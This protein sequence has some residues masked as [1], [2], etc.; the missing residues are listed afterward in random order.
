MKLFL[1]ST[2]VFASLLVSAGA[3]RAECN[4]L[5]VAGD[6]S[7]KIQ[8][9]V[10]E[11]DGL[12]VRGD[13][14]AALEIYASA[15]ASANDSVLL[16][17]QAMCQ[18]QLGANDDAAAM[19]EAY[20]E[21]GGDLAFRAQAEGALDDVRAGVAAGVVGVV[22]GVGGVA[23]GV[24]GG[25]EGGVDGGVGV[26]GGV[27][28]KVKPKKL[29]KGPAILL[30]VVAVVAV[31]AVLVHGIMAGLNDD[32]DPDT[33]LDSLSFDKKFGIGMGLTGVVVGATAFYLYGLTAA[34]G[35]VRCVSALEKHNVAPVVYAGG[36]GG[37][38][39][40]GSF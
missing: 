12:Y 35:A 3:A 26:V 20:L 37:L 11:A 14:D 8:A 18:W 5:S 22:G 27:R 10:A 7:A 13:Y 6:V 31:G 21:A 40:G 36:G 34:S 28:G 1:I 24:R 16:Y 30:G 29:A 39:A 32:I 23:G 4:C 2:L 38:S 25:V 9:Q 33:G 19:F 15:Y 17:A